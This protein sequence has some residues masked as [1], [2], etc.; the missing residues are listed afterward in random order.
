MTAFLIVVVVV[1]VGLV[2]LVALIPDPEP[3]PP[4]EVV[5]G[6]ISAGR[7]AYRAQVRRVGSEPV[8]TLRV[9]RRNEL[10]C[11]EQVPVARDGDPWDQGAW[12]SR[13]DSVVNLARVRHRE[14]GYRPTVK[15]DE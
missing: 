4:G 15:G 9:W 3:D 11:T 7:P 12:Q 2:V 13:A 6:N 1:V 8:A 10:I 5:W 14:Y